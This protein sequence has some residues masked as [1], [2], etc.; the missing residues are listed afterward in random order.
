MIWS[1][2]IFPEKKKQKPKNHFNQQ[3]STLTNFRDD[4]DYWFQR[5]NETL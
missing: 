5:T 2:T 3:I 4:K 1:N